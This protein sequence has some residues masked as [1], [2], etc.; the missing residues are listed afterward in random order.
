[1]AI[2]TYISLWCPS[3][4]FVKRYRFARDPNRREEIVSFVTGQSKALYLSLSLSFLLLS[5]SIFVVENSR[6]SLL[7]VITRKKGGGEGRGRRNRFERNK[8]RVKHCPGLFSYFQ[9]ELN[10]AGKRYF[11]TRR[12][13]LRERERER[14]ASLCVKYEH[15]NFTTTEGDNPRISSLTDS[16]GKTFE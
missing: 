15:R 10:I 9:R 4:V 7:S 5:Q 3:P 8:P 12:R 6:L 14:F 1:M 11:S 13:R 16:M 2:D